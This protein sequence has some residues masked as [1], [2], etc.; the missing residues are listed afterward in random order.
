MLSNRVGGGR[1]SRGLGSGVRGGVGGSLGLGRRLRG[2]GV[3][4][5]GRSGLGGFA[6][7][8]S[9]VR[10]GLGDRC[11]SLWADTTLATAVTRAGGYATLNRCTAVVLGV[12]VEGGGADRASAVRR[13]S[14]GHE[15]REGSEDRKEDSGGD[16]C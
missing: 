1:L 9:R 10:G 4:A 15:R 6:G 7:L 2:V 3:V 16:H 12:G 13:L 8:R 14:G 5:G 11:L